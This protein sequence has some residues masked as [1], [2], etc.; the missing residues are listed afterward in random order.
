MSVCVCVGGGVDV[1]GGGGGEGGRDDGIEQKRY[2]RGDDD[3]VG[4]ITDQRGRRHSWGDN[5]AE[6]MITPSWS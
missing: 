1:G 5:R 2:Q 3:I 6:R 4:I